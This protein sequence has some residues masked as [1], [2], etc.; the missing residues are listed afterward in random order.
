[1]NP[2]ESRLPYIHYHCIIIQVYKIPLHNIMKREVTK[3]IQGVHHIKTKEEYSGPNVI[4]AKIKNFLL[5]THFDLLLSKQHLHLCKLS[6]ILQ[7]S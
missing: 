2:S 5:H 6:L 4:I 1:M 3:L 7:M